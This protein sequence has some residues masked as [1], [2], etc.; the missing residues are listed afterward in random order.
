MSDKFVTVKC[1]VPMSMIDGKVILMHE[2]RRVRANEAA[3]VMNRHPG[4]FVLVNPDG[5][6]IAGALEEGTAGEGGE[7]GDGDQGDQGDQGDGGVD[8]ARLAAELKANPGMTAAQAGAL[9]GVSAT[10][11]RATEA[12][13]NRGA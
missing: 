10:K 11:I 1:C 12:W 3:A 2:W 8:Q 13:R 7:G 5:T 4:Y 9:F 6:S